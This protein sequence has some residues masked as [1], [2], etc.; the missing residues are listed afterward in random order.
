[1]KEIKNII[2]A[3]DKAMKQ[4]KQTALA[5]VVHVEGSSYRRPGA[6]MLITED[7]DLTGAI[8]GGCLEGD[9][10]RKALFVLNQQKSMLVTY[11]T[12]DED[13]AKLGV[14][15]GCSGII[16]VLIEPVNP[17]HENNPIALLR[18][19]SS[20]RQNSIL[21]TLYSLQNR[22]EV[23]QGTCFVF[24][25]EKIIYKGEKANS[26]DEQLLRD[27]KSVLV[28]KTSAFKNYISE[29]KDITAFIEFIKP[30]VSLIIIGA[31]NDV[32]PL[33][34]MAD[35][36]GWETTVVGGR[37]S[38]LKKERF[39]KA[40]QVLVL[41]PDELLKEIIIDEQT[42]F[43][44][45]THNY[46]HDLA[47]LKELIKKDIPYIGSLGPKKK[48]D[49]M[50]SELKEGGIDLTDKQLANIYGPSGLNIGA[51][52]PEEIALS[53][54]AEIKKVLAGKDG[55]ML[56]DNIDVIHSRSE[57]FIEKISIKD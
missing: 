49:K 31:G 24:N 3:F 20:K 55:K 41:K 44:L 47:V 8:S 9:A 12:T 19:V 27:I 23:Q 56:R 13:D 42:V 7:G 57:T 28:N 39:A 36:L 25:E 53:I 10:L 1:M 16:Q 38:N 29:K 50:I 54:L 37:S 51:E 40:C 15:L 21:V 4:G 43:V 26:P 35:V 30:V 34:Q 32:V 6:R 2:H 46:N 52:T 18:S 14:G 48:L 17:D 5:T 22:R 33:A 45:M 11:D